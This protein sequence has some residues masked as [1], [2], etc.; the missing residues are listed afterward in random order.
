[1]G[2][3]VDSCPCQGRVRGDRGIV[4][5]VSRQRA[6]RGL[7]R[8][9]VRL[10]QTGRTGRRSPEDRAKIPKL[11]RKCHDA[12][13]SHGYRWV[14]A[15]LAKNDDIGVSADYIRR[16][17]RY[18]GISAKTKHR[19]KQAKRASKE[20]Y[21]NLIFATWETVDRPRQVIVSDMTAF[22]TRSK[23]FEPALYFDVLAEQIAGHGLAERRGYAGIYY[24][25]LKQAIDV[26]NDGKERAVGT[27]EEGC[28][29]ICV[30]HTDYAEKNAK[31]QISTFPLMTA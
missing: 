8:E 3:R 30:M 23:Y 15:Y 2:R 18:L 4:Q 25:G 5:G 11:V 14:H 21:P 17:F 10:L 16:C 22:W 31:P 28:G 20:T 6:L 29:E 27:L 24:D 19:A 9:Q 1:M 7:R 12:H 13:P 26:I